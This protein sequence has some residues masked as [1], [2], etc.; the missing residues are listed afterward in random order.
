VFSTF[1]FHKCRVC[2]CRL[3]LFTEFPAA[4]QLSC[5]LSA[6]PRSVIPTSIS[7]SAQCQLKYSLSALLPACR[8]SCKISAQ[9]CRFGC[10]FVTSAAI[11]QSSNISSSIQQQ[12]VI[13]S[14]I[15]LLQLSTAANTQLCCHLSEQ[16]QSFKLQS[17]A[18]CHH[19]LHSSTPAWL[20][21][22]HPALQLCCN[23]VAHKPLPRTQCC[24]EV[25]LLACLAAVSDVHNLLLRPSGALANVSLPPRLF[26]KLPPTAHSF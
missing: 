8:T 5:N 6:W 9:D 22:K 24:A 11:C 21:W 3:S 18:K 1:L 14:S 2:G 20:S 26:G 16:L 13:T 7:T 17:S 15:Q 19:K 10:K 12:F 4:C 25:L 23:A